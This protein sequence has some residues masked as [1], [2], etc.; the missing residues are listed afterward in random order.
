VQRAA[1][2]FSSD[3]P[4]YSLNGSPPMNG[5]RPI[6]ARVEIAVSSVARQNVSFEP[7]FP[8]EAFFYAFVIVDVKRVGSFSFL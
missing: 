8:V 3:F 6:C 5:M 2:N 7:F 1:R 4:F